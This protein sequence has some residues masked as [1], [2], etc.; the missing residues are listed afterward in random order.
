MCYFCEFLYWK[1]NK[2]NKNRHGPRRKYQNTKKQ[3][4]A[5][6]IGKKHMARSFLI[7]LGKRERKR[8]RRAESKKGSEKARR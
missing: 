8:K 7:Y 6:P 2:E 5:D 1:G 3:G 4:A